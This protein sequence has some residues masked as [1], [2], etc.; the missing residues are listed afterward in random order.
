[1][2]CEVAVPDDIPCRTKRGQR[3]IDYVYL[4]TPGDARPQSLRMLDATCELKGPARPTLWVPSG[5]WYE[6]TNRR[7]PFGVKPDVAKQHERSVRSPESEHYVLWVIERPD[8]GEAISTALAR[9]LGKLTTDLP[10]I[11]LRECARHDS[12]GL[13]IFFFRVQ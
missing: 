11:S 6:R 10:T 7:E 8:C 12:N 5:N 9:L 4:D 3:K 2:R 13:W 1:M